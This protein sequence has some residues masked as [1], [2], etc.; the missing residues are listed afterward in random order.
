MA[1]KTV[2]ENHTKRST[3]LLRFR[4]IDGHGISYDRHYCLACTE[5]AKA[6]WQDMGLAITED[7]VGYVGTRPLQWCGT[8]GCSVCRTNGTAAIAKEEA[9]AGPQPL[10]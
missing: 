9:W 7:D 10:T 1:L 8:E 3:W 5:E 2:C 6:E 4:Y